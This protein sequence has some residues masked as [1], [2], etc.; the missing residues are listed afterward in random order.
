ML[1]RSTLL[2]AAAVVALS[3]GAASAD[4]QDRHQNDYQYGSGQRTDSGMSAYQNGYNF[5]YDDGDAHRDRN[6]RYR[7]D[8]YRFQ[9][10]GHGY[11]RGAYFYGND[12]SGDTATGTVLG[13]IAG[14]VVGNQFGHGDGRTAATVGGVI[15]GGI[16]GNSIA[17]D[18]NCNDRHYALTSYSAGFDGRIGE[19][20]DWRSNEGGDYGRFTPTR[21]YS[22]S[23]NVCRDFQDVSY[24]DGRE[25]DRNGT[26]CRQSDGNWYLQ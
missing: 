18:L 14:G 3:A 15:L 2:L 5:G 22:R 11:D 4:S 6:D 23:G 26:A 10:H 25:Y 17:R 1:R 20:Y 24:R 8:N 12:C 7:A 16:A 9:H 21:E 19:H 13:A